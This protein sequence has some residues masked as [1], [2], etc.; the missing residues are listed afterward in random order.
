MIN[1]SR[2]ACEIDN[3]LP[4]FETPRDTEG[5]EGFFHL[6][7]ING[8]E[9]KT[10]SVYIVRDHDAA[11]YENR[12]ETLRHIEK[13]MNEKW[14]A[15]TVKLTISESYRNMEEIID[16]CMFTIEYAKEAAKRVGL[17][18]GVTPIRGGTDGSQL[19]FRGLP[20]PNLGTGG[21]S[22]HGPYEHATV[23]G[24][25]LAAEMVVELVKVYAEK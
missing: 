20:C 15:G 17:S 5:Y 12:K 3:A 14:G 21:H 24:I 8:D 4:A 7:G 10:Q 19:S 6:L 11:S 13:L 22:F 1:A 2:L 16:D 23:E 18:A 25:E 9:S